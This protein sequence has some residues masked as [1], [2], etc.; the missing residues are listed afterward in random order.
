M[1]EDLWLWIVNVLY[2]GFWLYGAAYLSLGIARPASFHAFWSINNIDE[3]YQACDRWNPTPWWMYIIMAL[4]VL[5][6]LVFIYSA[7]SG[8]VTVIPETLGAVDEDG[9]W[10][11]TRETVAGFIAFGGLALLRSFDRNA[12]LLISEPIER[13]AR[14]AI[15]AA[16]CS[17]RHATGPLLTSLADRLVTALPGELLH[18]HEYQKEWADE[19]HAKIVG[20]VR[21][22]AERQVAFD[23][24]D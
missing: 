15:L 7:A 22:A 13:Q 3:Q 23:A 8:F 20:Q 21:R 9:E 19:V 5:A 11:G 10:A 24:P 14:E 16:V 18:P 12:S 4:R 1:N 17:D 6:V 2:A